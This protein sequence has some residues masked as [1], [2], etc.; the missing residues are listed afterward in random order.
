VS[1][2][3]GTS[4]DWTKPWKL[5]LSN[6]D[7]QNWVEKPGAVT[8]STDPD[9]PTTIVDF[10]LGSDGTWKHDVNDHRTLKFHDDT[11]C[12]GDSEGSRCDHL[13]N[14]RVVG[15]SPTGGSVDV[16]GQC[17]G[18]ACRIIIGTPGTNNCE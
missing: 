8:I 15:T 1:F 16:T 2:P 7:A 9:N 11:A 18:G 10:A 5:I 3:S 12:K 17:L 13:V 14:V 6:L 4:L